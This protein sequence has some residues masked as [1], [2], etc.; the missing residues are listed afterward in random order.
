MDKW[1]Y[2]L[3][4]IWSHGEFDDEILNVCIDGLELNS[5]EARAW[6][7]RTRQKPLNE[8]GKEGWELI[9]IRSKSPL[10]VE[11]LYFKK[12]L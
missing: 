10:P 8:L 1:E 7:D 6:S 3:V 12:I 4:E 5:E 11:F 9:T 2:K